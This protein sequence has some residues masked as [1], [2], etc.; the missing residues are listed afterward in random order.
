MASLRKREKI[1]SLEADRD[2]V[3]PVSPNEIG[4]SRGASGYLPSLGGAE[5]AGSLGLIRAPSMIEQNVCGMRAGWHGGVRKTVRTVWVFRRKKNVRGAH[6]P[7][8][9]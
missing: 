7:K 5:A 6:R 9:G 3:S 2:Q 8:R 1:H 4:R